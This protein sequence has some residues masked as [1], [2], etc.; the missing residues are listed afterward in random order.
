MGASPC[1]EAWK[2][3]FSGVCVGGWGGMTWALVTGLRGH[4]PLDGGHLG[5]Q[6]VPSRA[7]LLISHPQYEELQTLA[8]KHG[9]DLRRTKTEISETNRNINRLRAEIDGLKG[10]V[11]AGWGVGEDAETH[12]GDR[13]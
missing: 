4:S 13:R 9:D 10:Q 3:A 2:K 11:W 6:G 1:P 7:P 5:F 8:G 12:L